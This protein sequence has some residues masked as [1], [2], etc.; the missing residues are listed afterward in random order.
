MKIEQ[1]VP[2]KKLSQYSQQMGM[3]LVK[4]MSVMKSEVLQVLRFSRWKIMEVSKGALLTL[5][6][7]KDR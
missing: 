4:K 1:N 2:G 3:G 7:L 6:Q 5:C